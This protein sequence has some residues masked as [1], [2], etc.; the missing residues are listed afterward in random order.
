MVGACFKHA[1]TIDDYNI[2]KINLGVNFMWRVT[3]QCSDDSWRFHGAA[4]KVMADKYPG[5]LISSKK[6][7]GDDRRI[8]SYQIEDVSDAEDF[9]ADCLQMEG[10]AAMFEAL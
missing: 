1:P 3:I 6:M 9:V 5:T 10:L 4:F 8:M 2:F 7:P